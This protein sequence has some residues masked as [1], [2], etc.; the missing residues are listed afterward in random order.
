MWEEGPRHNAVLVFAEHRMYGRSLPFPSDQRSHMGYL[1]SEQVQ[2]LSSRLCV[3][4]KTTRAFFQ[5]STMV[6]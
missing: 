5:H 1:T 4:R 6:P 3:C 2:G